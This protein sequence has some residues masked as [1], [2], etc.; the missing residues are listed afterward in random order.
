M[1]SVSVNEISE[2]LQDVQNKGAGLTNNGE[3]E[4]A[5]QALLR[6]AQ[7]LVNALQSPFEVV[8]KMNW[9][10][11]RFG[12]ERSFQELFYKGE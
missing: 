3:N 11:V 7:N 8:A 4:A 6:S 1:G 9:L 2:L 10:E 12:Q 5:R